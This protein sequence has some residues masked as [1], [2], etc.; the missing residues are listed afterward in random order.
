GSGWP[1]GI[2]SAPS[3]MFWKLYVI[4]IGVPLPPGCGHWSPVRTYCPGV[5]SANTG[6]GRELI[7]PS[8]N[9]GAS[10]FGTWAFVRVAKAA[11]AAHSNT[12]QNAFETK[13]TECS[14]LFRPGFSAWFCLFHCKL[15][16]RRSQG[17]WPLRSHSDPPEKC[18]RALQGRQKCLT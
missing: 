5:P 7:S 10:A 14:A 15:A 3:N 2:L 8:A 12:D 16:M 18:G 6:S 1:L 11:A 17:K 13:L 4:V 9:S